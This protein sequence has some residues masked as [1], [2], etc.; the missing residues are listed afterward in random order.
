M[1]DLRWKGAHAP[2]DGDWIVAEIP[3]NG[4]AHLVEVLGADDR[5]EWDLSLIHI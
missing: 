2:E 5:P 1:R 4:P 3:W